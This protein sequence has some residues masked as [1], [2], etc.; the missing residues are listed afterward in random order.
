MCPL[1]SGSLLAASLDRRSTLRLAWLFLG[2]LLARGRRTVTSWIRAAGLS[3]QFCPCYTTVAAAGRKAKEIAARLVCEVVK[4]LVADRTRLTLAI[5]DTPTQRYGPF[6]QGAGLHHNPTPG[7]AGSP[8][9]YGHIW[10][11][12]GLL[13]VH[14]AW[15]V[16][17]LPLLA[18]MYVRVKNL[19]SIYPQ[20]RPEFQ[21]KLEMAVEL[22][23]WAHFWLKHLGKP[24]WVVVD[25]AYAKA[26]FL[27]PAMALGMTVVSRLRKDAALWTVPGPRVAGRRGRPRIYGE[28]RIELAK[29]AGQRR[30][31]MTKVFELYGKQTKK[32][33]KTFL[34]TGRWPDSRR[35]GRRAGR[36][37]RLLLHRPEC[38]RGRDPRNG[39]RSIHA[40]D[41]VPRLQGDRRG[42][43]TAGAIRVGKH[44]CIPHMPLDVHD[45]QGVGVESTGG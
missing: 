6:V 11:V 38:E 17:A 10:V 20:H 31:W 45:D 7:P 27:K 8:H 26:P 5:D 33:Y 19:P 43:P 30:G 29:R 15:G 9:V 22:L 1:A 36:L 25:G 14:P 40:G 13:A 4:P 24:L 18:R 12:L 23:Q 34:A 42:R 41:H 35:A 3:D 44:R 39:C 37:G 32:R 28:N 2:A 21:T 16:I